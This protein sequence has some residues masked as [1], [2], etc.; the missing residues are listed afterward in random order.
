MRSH[1]CSGMKGRKTSTINRIAIPSKAFFSLRHHKTAVIAAMASK[2]PRE[3][4]PMAAAAHRSI[5]PVMA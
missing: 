3:W 2:A 4:L 1:Q 5:M